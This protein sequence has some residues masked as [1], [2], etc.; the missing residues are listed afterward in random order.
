[1]KTRAQ[2][3]GVATLPMLRRTTLYV[4]VLI[5]EPCKIYYRLKQGKSQA[6][7]MNRLKNQFH[8]QVIC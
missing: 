8:I 5:W 3:A 7:P 1:M 2:K 6:I 4:L